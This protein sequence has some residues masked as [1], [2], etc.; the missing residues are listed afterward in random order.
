MFYRLNR[1]AVC[2]NAKGGGRSS[3]S[4][5]KVGSLSNVQDTKGMEHITDYYLDTHRFW[6]IEH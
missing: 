1:E 5:L 4:D 2:V 3:E 6:Q